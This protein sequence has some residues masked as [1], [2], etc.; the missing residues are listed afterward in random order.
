MLDAA[1]REK[2]DCNPAILV[3]KKPGRLAL[4]GSPRSWG[5][6]ITCISQKRKRTGAPFWLVALGHFFS[7]ISSSW[8]LLLSSA[9]SPGSLSLL[10]FPL[11]QP[12]CLCISL[13]RSRSSRTTGILLLRTQPVAQV[14]LWCACTCV[15]GL[16]VF[17]FCSFYMY[18]I[19]LDNMWSN[20]VVV[21][22]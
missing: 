21:Y 13:S 18:E 20:A 8:I 16:E 19:A 3:G 5:G 14:V 17:G 9:L 6:A 4:Q 10:L 7:S 15:V 11:I 2:R 12:I 1:K 22:V